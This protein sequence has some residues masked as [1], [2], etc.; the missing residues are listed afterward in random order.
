M[1]NK[2]PDYKLTNIDESF[3]L[4]M[5]A[6]RGICAYPGI[7]L[8]L[9]VDRQPSIIAA[10]IAS[11]DRGDMIFLAMQ[12]DPDMENPGTE[13]ICTVGTVCRL[14]EI[15]KFTG[16]RMRLVAEPTWRENWA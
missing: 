16:M 13:D 3:A 4:T 6:M 14:T 1:I 9:E 10:R 15:V 2:K 5:I 12:K 11:R 7:T 8:S